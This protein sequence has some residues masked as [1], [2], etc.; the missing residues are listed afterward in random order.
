[1]NRP[2]VICHM[3]T[4]LDG[5]ISGDFMETATAAPAL[6]AYN[7]LRGFYDCRATL[8]GTTTMLGGYANGLA[9]LDENFASVAR[10]D[11][12]APAAQEAQQLIIAL[13]P[14]GKLGYKSPIIEREGRAPA[15]V[16]EVLTE[17][18]SDAYLQYL[19]TLGVSY[20]FCGTQT[21]DVPPLLE[22]L[23]AALSVRSLMLA[24]GGVT[25][26][27]F[28]TAGCIDELSLVVAPVTSGKARGLS[29]FESAST[30]EI[31]K[32]FSLV[33]MQKLEGDTLWLRYR[34]I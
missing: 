15:V 12:L 6:R 19:R 33:E 21:I 1:M 10:E 29:I 34:K 5:K 3:C 9:Q 26:A 23:C 16:V 20:L 24:G 28:L 13:D 8:Y 31:T 17:Q 22:K 4:S 32:D 14:E 18:A 2:W 11:Y 25:N 30:K 7:E 27:P